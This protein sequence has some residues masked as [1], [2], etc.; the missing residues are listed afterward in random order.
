MKYYVGHLSTG[1]SAKYKHKQTILFDSLELA[2]GFADALKNFCVP[3]LLGSG[4][5]QEVMNI[6]NI[7]V[8]HIEDETE[9]NILSSDEYI[10]FKDIKK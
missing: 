7:V 1:V 9:G 5:V 8:F 6:H 4:L 3:H 10:N 2:L